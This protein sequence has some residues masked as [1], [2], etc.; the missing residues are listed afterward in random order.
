M[1]RREDKHDPID[2]DAVHTEEQQQVT[3]DRIIQ[4]QRDIE[5]PLTHYFSPNRYGRTVHGCEETSV[6]PLLK[7]LKMSEKD[8]STHRRRETPS[9]IV[10]QIS[11]GQQRVL[12]RHLSGLGM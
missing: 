4:T 3:F 9:H 5:S 6:E 10:P 1:S 2:H 8:R 7:E 11:E 12:A